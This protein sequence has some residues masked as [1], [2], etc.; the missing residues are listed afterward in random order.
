MLAHAYLFDAA[1]WAPQIAALAGRYRVIVP[2]MWGHGHS[3]PLPAKS[4]T[5]ADL[6]RHHLELLDALGLEQCAIVGLSLGG[7]WA[8]ELALEAPDRVSGLVLMDT[9]LA[10]EPAESRDQLLGLFGMI[11]Q[12]GAFEPAVI[13]IAVQRFF[14]PENLRSDPA[15]G[16]AVATRLR[17]WDRARLADSVV[18]I[19][20][21]IF[22]RREALD[23]LGSLPMPTLVVTGA[24]DVS[25]PAAE[26]RAMAKILGCDFVSI[27]DAGH[28][29]S[30]EAPDAVNGTLLEFLDGLALP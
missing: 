25:W 6:A 30:L 3:G 29:V 10:A 18:P 23:E 16:E 20:R 22:G 7:M 26:G 4:G 5:L 24:Q 28:I 15:L 13:D 8:A 2:E 1:M 9:S 19:G 21:M 14:T 17:N 11:A 12:A 27:P